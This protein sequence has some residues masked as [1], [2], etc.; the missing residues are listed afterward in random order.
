VVPRALADLAQLNDDDLFFQLARG[1]RL[2]LTNALQ[3]WRDAKLLAARRRPQGFQIIKLLA[4]EEAAKFHILLDATRCPRNPSDR[5]SR[6]LKYFSEHLARGLYTEYYQWR[7][8]TLAE[9]RSHI[10]RERQALYL[11]GPNDVDWIFRNDIE[12]RRE[13]AMYVDYVAVRD[14]FHDEHVWHCPNRRL[15]GMYLYAGAP[16]VLCVADALHHGGMTSAD[17]VRLVAQV[18]RNMPPPDT[19]TW[20][21][22]RDVN[23]QTLN[24]LEDRHLLR[25]A[26]SATYTMI[27]N[28]W[29]APLYQLDL[30]RLDVR[31][32]D[33][34]DAQEH[35]VPPDVY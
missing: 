18:W 19:M 7:P 35:W 10:D 12:R 34:R 5:F 9:A 23:T 24:R 6:H 14:H 3:L 32:A 31:P 22:L 4:E 26:S 20:E 13:E 29:R 15:L 2:S 17:A 27:A 33:L 1:M 11:D 8:M 16:N 28:E 25:A 30:T 21:Q